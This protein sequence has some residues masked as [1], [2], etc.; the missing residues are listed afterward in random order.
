MG[1]IIGKVTGN[2]AVGIAASV[3]VDSDHII[4][5]A[6]NGTLFHPKELWKSFSKP[7]VIENEFQERN[8]LHNIFIPIA[9]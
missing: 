7:Q 9:L 6:K 1:M 5:L 4:A 3:L 2:Y 8:Y